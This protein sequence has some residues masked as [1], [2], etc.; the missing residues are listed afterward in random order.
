M[1]RAIP[2]APRIN[3]TIYDNF[4]GVDFTNDATNIWKHRSPDAVNMMPDLAGR[5]WKRTGWK[6]EKTTQAFKDCY[7]TTKGYDPED[8]DYYTGRIVPL[9]TNYFTIGGEDFLAITNNLGLF[10]YS[11][12]IETGNF[13]TPITSEEPYLMYIKCYY[14]EVGTST[15]TTPT[16]AVIIP[17]P[18]RAFFFEGFGTAGFYIFCTIGTTTSL[19]RFDGEVLRKVDP[20]V[21]VIMISKGSGDNA[22][23]LYE[24][25]NILTLKR[26]VMFLAD[27]TSKEYVLPEK[28]DSVSSVEIASGA[29]WTP[30]TDPTDYSTENYSFGGKTVTKIKFGNAPSAPDVAGE[31]N[32]RVTY[33]IAG[34]SASTTTTTKQ[35]I[36]GIGTRESQTRTIVRTV[37]DGDETETITPWV[38]TSSTS[39]RQSFSSVI[40]NID[41]VNNE[42]DI[43]VYLKTDADTWSNYALSSVLLDSAYSAYTNTLTVN[44]KDATGYYYTPSTEESSVTQTSDKVKITTSDADDIVHAFGNGVDT[45]VTKTV[46]KIT[47]QKYVT[48]WK[49][50]PIKVEAT[51]RT[52]SGSPLRNAFDACIRTH[53][54]GDG[55]INSV[56]FTGS[57]VDAYRS[58]VW[59]SATNDPTYFPDTNY[60]E[61]G[62]NDTRIAGLIDVGEYLGIIKQGQSRTST[63]YLAYKTSVESGQVSTVDG[64]GKTTT[65]TTYDVTYGVKTSIGGVGAISNGAFNILNGEPLFLS[66]EGIMGIVPV[67]E[68]EKQIRNRSFYINKKLLAEAGLENSFSFVWRNM[69]ILAVNHH[70]YVLD[71]SQK[72]SWANEKTNLQYEAYYWENIP[73]Q[74]FAKYNNQL[75][76]TDYD[77]RLCRFKPEGIN[78]SYHDEYDSSVSLEDNTTPLG[79]SAVTYGYIPLSVISSNSNVI[80]EINADVFWSQVNQAGSYLFAL[81]S[82]GYLHRTHFG[83]HFARDDFKGQGMGNSGHLDVNQSPRG[84]DSI[85]SYF[86]DSEGWHLNGEPANIADYGITFT[87]ESEDPKLNDTIKI[88]AGAP[89]VARWTTIFDDDGSANYFKTLQ[90]KGTMVVLYPQSSTGVRVYLRKDNNEPVYVGTAT[91]RGSNNELT[92]PS[93]F[94]LKKK[95]KKYKR[96][97]II[98]ENDGL[99]ETFGIDEII[100][101]YTVGNYSRNR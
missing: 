23:V 52:Y 4:R 95:A 84:G 94:Y 12:F 59:W 21:P 82:A 26:T 28:A 27:G 90:K 13:V 1:A 61:V 86:H 98:T 33:A 67:N 30:K 11:K 36:I 60:F 76:F 25:P 68:N 57:T 42:P 80:P 34:S 40:P 97:Q 46:T 6:I 37:M 14:G 35:G 89:I 55:L 72:S 87:D 58:R 63:V 7:N 100:K 49:W 18:N 8:P 71:G 73:A 45:S 24:S 17:D 53:V 78:D 50:Y 70:C 66:K 20:K 51:V 44:C 91:V 9:K 54:F 5:P 64:N 15:E 10:F 96:L 3:T 69:Y 31:D 79:E 99:D 2:S 16:N 38:V 62:S 74:C 56:F 101:C 65:E 93:D 75:W 47:E 22:G 39:V 29:N 85:M 77:G 92:A 48:K 43:S 81:T 32:I 41:M 88:T 19:F 83:A